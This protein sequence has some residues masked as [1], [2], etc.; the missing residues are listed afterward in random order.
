ME[1]AFGTDEV[2]LFKRDRATAEEDRA[3]FRS[4]Q[5]RQVQVFMMTTLVGLMARSGTFNRLT[6]RSQARKDAHFSA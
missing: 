5:T 4:L 1:A 6:A 3:T 2:W